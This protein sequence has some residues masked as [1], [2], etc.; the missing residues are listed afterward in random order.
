MID[1][2]IITPGRCAAALSI[3]PPHAFGPFEVGTGITGLLLA[4]IWRFSF[5]TSPIRLA[6]F[7]FGLR[8]LFLIAVIVWLATSEHYLSLVLPLLW[9][10]AIPVN[11]ESGKLGPP[12]WQFGQLAMVLLAV[13]QVLGLYPVDG[14]QGAP[15]FYLGSVCV[16]FVLTSLRADI[17][18]KGQSFFAPRRALAAAVSIGLALVVLGASWRVARVSFGRYHQY[19]SLDLPGARLLRTNEANKATYGFLV[20]NLQNCR[21]SFL[22]IPGVNSL[23]N[24]LE[25]EPPTGFN[26]G[27]NFLGLSPEQQRAMVDVGRT[28]QPIAAVLNRNLVAFWTRGYIQPS[29]PLIDFVTKECRVVGRVKNY[30]LMALHGAPAPEFTDCVTFDKE[31]RTDAPGNQITAF[32]PTNIGAITNESVL[33]DYPSG[34]AFYQLKA[35]D[36]NEKEAN[37]PTSGPRQ[38]LI[39]LPDPRILTKVSLD[40]TLIQLKDDA[41]RIINLPFLRPPERRRSK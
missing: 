29:G 41:G 10:A 25:R 12:V 33:Q 19:S 20:A 40:Q 7:T 24:W 1:G 14:G 21:P 13:A 2:L 38:F 30:E 31:W 6:W 4:V 34:T 26:V 28:C 17:E 32:L 18:M 8:L 36:T 3:V 16:I 27:M 39:Q 11:Q 23:Y 9:V 5:R 15:P 37:A 35:P 22:T